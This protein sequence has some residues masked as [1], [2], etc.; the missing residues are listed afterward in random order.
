MSS[1]VRI[2]FLG[3]LG[4]IG[5]N[6]FCLEVEGPHPR[7]R[8]RSDVPRRRHARRRPR[9]PGLHLPAGPRG[10]GRRDRAHARPRGPRRRRS[11]TSCV[12]SRRPI[13][14]SALSPRASPGTASRRPGCSARPTL[15][16]V[17]DGERHRHRPVRLRV[18]PGHALGAAR[19][20]R[21][22]PDAGGHDP[23]H[24]RL[25]A[26]PHPGRRPHAPTSPA[27]ARSAARACSCCCPTPP[28][29]SGRASRRRRRPSV[30]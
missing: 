6:C 2:V 4:E 29:P 24:G 21:R 16:P 7:R 15:V 5:R 9:P 13:Y 17:T 14:G 27:S 10:A 19:V 28:T 26:R 11:P 12:T 1:P 8:L 30:R 20:R 18:R 22:V 23:A 3:G 25:Q